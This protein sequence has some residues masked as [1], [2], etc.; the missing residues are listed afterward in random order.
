MAC[1][2]GTPWAVKTARDAATS[3][4]PMPRD[5]AVGMTLKR[6]ADNSSAFVLPSFTAVKSWSDAWA[7]LIV[8]G[9]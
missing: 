9:P 1:A 2:V 4:K 8:S 6:D 7:A 5:A 3:S